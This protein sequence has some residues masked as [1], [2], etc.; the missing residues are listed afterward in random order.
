MYISH[1]TVLNDSRPLG[2]TKNLDKWMQHELNNET[3][4]F[5]IEHL[6]PKATVVLV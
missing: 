3:I 1:P 4:I 6:N 2:K 5:N